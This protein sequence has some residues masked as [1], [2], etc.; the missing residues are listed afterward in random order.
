MMKMPAPPP[1]LHHRTTRDL[2]AAENSLLQV[3]R[4][5]QFGRIENVLVR[6]GQP[7]LDGEMKIVHVEYLGGAN[8]GT[9]VP[10]SDEF[11][12]RQPVRDLFDRLQRLGDGTIVRLDFKHGLPFLLETTAAR[13]TARSADDQKTWQAENV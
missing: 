10:T 12:L 5:Y 3:M 8:S 2:T 6:A 1:A 9:K 11:E 7:I 13:P 4:Q